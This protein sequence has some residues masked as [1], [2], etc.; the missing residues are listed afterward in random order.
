MRLTGGCSCGGVRFA[1][2]QYLFAQ[3]CHCDA[4]KKR[5]G[6]AYGMSVVI[7]NNHLEAFDGETRTFKRIGE[8]GNPV[9]YEFCPTCATTVRWRVAVLPDRQ[10]LAGGALD[11][12]HSLQMVGEMYTG[13]ALSW[14]RI[15]C[16]LTCAA[17]PDDVYRSALVARTLRGGTPPARA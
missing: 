15:G 7:A 9:E 14:A 2:R 6:S 3:V 10:V 1:I 5:T 11:D 4:C 8:S 12:P 16:E 17:A 13:E